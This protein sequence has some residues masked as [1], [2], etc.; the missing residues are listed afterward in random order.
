MVYW[1][2]VAALIATWVPRAS[3]AA[4]SGDRQALIVQ[5]IELV[6]RGKAEEAKSALVEVRKQDTNEPTVHLALGAALLHLGRYEGAEEEF[7]QVL[8]LTDEPAARQVAWSGLGVC[9]LRT[10]QEKKAAQRLGLLVDS[11]DDSAAARACLAYALFRLGDYQG[12]RRCAERAA[13]TPE[14]SGFA[15][16]VM[17]HT[18]SRSDPRKAVD[19]FSRALRS[20]RAGLSRVSLGQ[21][22]A[23]SALA[24]PASAAGRPVR[25]MR[26]GISRTGDEGVA[27]EPAY[28]P[29][30]THS[31]TFWLDGSFKSATN[32]PPFRFEQKVSRL[33][34][35]WHT[36]ALD[37]LD[38]NGQIIG[39]AAAGFRAD[40]GSAGRESN[41]GASDPAWV[42]TVAERLRS[43][44]RPVADIASLNYFLGRAYEN[45]GSSSRAAKHYE[46]AFAAREDEKDALQRLLRIYRKN[47][48]ALG[49]RAAEPLRG[50][51]RLVALTFDDGPN[52]LF[53]PRLLDILRMH[54]VRATFFM[55]GTQVL[56]WPD[57]ARQV[58]DEGHEIGNHSFSHPN[59]KLLSPERVEHE[60]LRAKVVIEQATGRATRLFRPPGGRFSDQAVRA[61]AAVGHRTVLWTSN[62]LE[63]EVR[64]PHAIALRMARELAGGGIALM[65]NGRDETVEVLP[66]LLAR[67]KTMGVRFVTVSELLAG[68]RSGR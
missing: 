40:N 27:I 43:V 28:L 3:S 33:G 57:L 39:G 56:S 52:P 41:A 7:D 29:G 10:G 54:K 14:V 65:H 25:E 16:A 26:V 37:A 30:K 42:R 45:V 58:A 38:A 6:R 22:A 20:S 50:K 68:E 31:V 32:R 24:L 8:L 36:M 2:L 18:Y 64:D 17:A 11:A 48:A 15:L 35:G 47:G 21:Q 67:L 46:A 59:M 34:P 51:A 44:V 4:P 66:Q 9:W 23:A 61:A 63:S 62:I 53:T 13:L 12:A 5:G 49:G 1:P 19:W 60:V 55:V